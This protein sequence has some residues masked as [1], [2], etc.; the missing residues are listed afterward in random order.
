[1]LMAAPRRLPFIVPMQATP[2]H[3]LPPDPAEWAAEVKWDG[4]RA[5]AYVADGAVTIRNR[6]GSDVTAAYPEIAVALA[7]AAGR[8][9]LVLDGVVTAFSGERPSLTRL[10]RRLHHA[11]PAGALV[12]SVPVTFVAFDL[13]RQAG[14][15]L[16]GNPYEQR[17]AL[18]DALALDRGHLRVP[19]AFPG[20][21]SEVTEASRQFGL[22]GVVFK[23]L[24]S[25]Y[26]P[27]RTDAWLTVKHVITTNV[28]IGGWLPGNGRR[29]HLAGSILAGD[30]TLN[31]L[32]FLGQVG[33]GFTEAE[34]AALTERLRDLEQPASPF[35]EPVPQAVAR[36]A[37]WTR[38]VLAGEV[39]YSEITPG[40]RL[41]QPIWRGLRPA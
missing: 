29:A 2:A 1:M 11:R 17:R 31:G 3:E 15:D 40:G 30:P 9:T 35:A 25:H 12:A 20:Q 13:L 8:R 36:R 7:Q 18:L 26:H 23:R 6:N 34:L 21:A 14:R 22:E 19:P 16:L 41:R 39:I 27:G 24:R 28:L 5:T 4:A 10:Q 33:S 38:P 37:R 32:E